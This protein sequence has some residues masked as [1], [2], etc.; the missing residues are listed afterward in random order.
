MAGPRQWEKESERESEKKITIQT[1][2]H[3]LHHNT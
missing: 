2:M 3:A 1:Q